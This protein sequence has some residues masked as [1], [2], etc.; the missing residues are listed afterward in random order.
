MVMGGEG[1]WWKGGAVW[2]GWAKVEEWDVGCLCEVGAGKEV[3]VV[4]GGMG[5][6]GLVVGV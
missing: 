1:V 5:D 4:V 3:V 2:V 6:V